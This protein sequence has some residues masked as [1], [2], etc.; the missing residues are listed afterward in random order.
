MHG[1]DE[2]YKILVRK[3]ERRRPLRRTSCRWKYNIK[4]DYR[5]IGWQFVDWIR[6]SQDGDQFRA[7]VDMVTNLQVP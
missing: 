5:E 1:S 2:A 6:L 7:L 4:I 3:P